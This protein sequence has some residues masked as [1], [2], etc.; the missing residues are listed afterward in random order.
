MKN[1]IKKWIPLFLLGAL[2]LASCASIPNVDWNLKIS[3]AV[4]NPLEVSYKE[5]AKMEQLDLSEILMDK[6]IGEDEITAW[7]G[8][9]LAD[10]LAQ[11]GAEEGF[12]SI[13]ALAADGYA[14]EITSAEAEGAIIAMQQSGEWIAEVD[15]DS[16]PIRLVCPQTPAN[17]WV[18][19]L[20]EIQINK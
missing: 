16:G 14:I 4:S 3:G 10:L 6:S 19:Q 12:V 9:P 15:P 5:L 20:Q 1:I 13:T 11:A 7:S 18:F 2:L 17:R 8:V